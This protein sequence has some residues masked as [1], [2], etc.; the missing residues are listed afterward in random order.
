MDPLQT[1][2]SFKSMGFFYKLGI[3]FRG[4]REHVR[5]CRPP[6][7]EAWFVHH[8]D[9]FALDYL[10]PLNFISSHYAFCRNEGTGGFP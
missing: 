7:Q 3:R 6:R 2:G 1:H 9:L 5:N 10:F 4:L 8:F